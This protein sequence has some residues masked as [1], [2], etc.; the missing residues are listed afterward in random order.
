LQCCEGL[1]KPPKQV[2]E[3]ANNL[4]KM[5][6]RFDHEEDSGL[7]GVYKAFPSE[8]TESSL[9]AQE[10][11]QHLKRPEGGGRLRWFHQLKDRTGGIIDIALYVSEEQDSAWIPVGVIEVGFADGTPKSSQAAAYGINVAGQLNSEHRGLLVAELLL[12]HEHKNHLIKL[13]ALAPALKSEVKHKNEK[14]QIWYAP[15]WEGETNDALALARMLWAFVSVA[16]IN[17]RPSTTHTR[18]GGN[19]CL[20]D[21]RIYKCYDYRYNK[22]DVHPNQRRS[23]DLYKQ[24][25]DVVDVLKK[26]NLSL[27]SYPFVDGDH[28]AKC[29]GQFVQVIKQLCDLHENG[30]CHGDIR[31]SNIVFGKS[32][33]TRSTLIDF[34]FG[35]E[36]KQ[37]PVGYNR[38][39]PDG[40]RHKNAKAGEGL[41]KEHDWFAMAKVMKLHECEDDEMWTN[42]VQHVEEN[43]VA[44]ALELLREYL[45]KDLKPTADLLAAFHQKKIATGS[46]DRLAKTNPTKRDFYN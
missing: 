28:Y 25:F 24:F 6:K 9:L 2:I 29:V 23:P 5:L 45:K 27:I 3:C 8:L 12:D 20:K 36:G 42:A 31:A 10:L 33:S 43:E 41:S 21:G 7:F 19:T 13:R 26:E 18:I 16:E 11:G 22:P 15:V 46:P 38:D 30:F 34:D 39:I 32:I 40:A 35:G 4:I 14:D 17:I 44:T 37:Y 1:E